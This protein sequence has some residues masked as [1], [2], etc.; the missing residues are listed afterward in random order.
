MNSDDLENKFALRLERERQRYMRAIRMRLESMREASSEI[1]KAASVRAS[2]PFSSR[3]TVASEPWSI[4][5]PSSK[6][7]ARVPNRAQGSNW[8][9]TIARP[10]LL[11]ASDDKVDLIYVLVDA[12]LHC[13]LPERAVESLN[14]LLRTKPTPAL[15]EV[16]P[17]VWS[18]VQGLEE[19]ATSHGIAVREMQKERNA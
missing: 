17:D 2:E 12:K 19:W 16:E 4:P 1:N 5:V 7:I 15:I 10:D 11:P 9:I 3:K 6:S 18:R 14:S 13:L 8:L